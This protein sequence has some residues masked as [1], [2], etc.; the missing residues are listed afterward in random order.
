M[1][2]PLYN[3][4]ILRLAASIPYHERLPAPMGSAEKRSPVCGSRVAVDVDV[5]EDGRVAAIGMLVRA[6]ALGQ[7]SSALMA[8][9]SE[10]RRGGK[11]GVGTCRYRGSPFH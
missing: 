3:T 7:A 1:A 4:D 6:C 10:E 2:A 9:R 11:E 8:A 5:D